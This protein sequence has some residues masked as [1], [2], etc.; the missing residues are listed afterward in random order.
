MPESAI[1]LKKRHWHRCFPMNFTKSLRTH[2]FI[3]QLRV[4]ASGELLTEIK[5]SAAGMFYRKFSTQTETAT[6]R[7]L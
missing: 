3:E 1:L 2:F 5:G 6:G 7:V 4:T